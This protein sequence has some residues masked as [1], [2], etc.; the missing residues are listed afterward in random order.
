[1]TNPANRLFEEWTEQVRDLAVFA[2]IATRLSPG[3]RL[4]VLRAMFETTDPTE[5]KRMLAWLND[6]YGPMNALRKSIEN[7]Q[8]R[9]E[10]P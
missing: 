9:K 6:Q 1:M 3:Q 7:L 5:Q 8:K 4:D 2:E 10:K